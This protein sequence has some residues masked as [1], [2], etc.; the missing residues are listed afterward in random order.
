MLVPSLGLLSQLLREW[1]FAAAIPFEVLCV[2]SDQTVGTRGNDE[3]IHSVADLAFPVTSDVEEVKNFLS[4]A[5]NCV[6]SQ[7]TNLPP[8][9]P[10]PKPTQPSPHLIWS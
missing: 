4:G 5:G 1:M 2:C 3:A 10:Q 7:P 6:V 9:S 8:S